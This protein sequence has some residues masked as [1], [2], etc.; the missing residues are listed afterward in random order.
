MLDRLLGRASLQRAHRRTRS[1]KR[2]VAKALRGRIR[3]PSRRRDGT[4]GR[5]GA[6]QPARGSDRPARGRTRAS[7]RGRDR[8]DRST[9]RPASRLPTRGGSRP[10]CVPPNG[11]RGC[12][13]RQRGRRGARIGP[14]GS[15][16]RARRSG[17]ARRRR[18][19]VSV[20]RRRRRIARRDARAADHPDVDAAW[21]DRFALEREWFLPT[22]RHAVA[23]VRTDLFALGVY[24]DDERVDYRGFES[25]VKGSHSKGGFSQARFERIRDGQIDDHLERCRD[26]L[27]AYEPGANAPIRRSISSA[28]GAPST[29]SSTN[30][31]S[32]RPRRPPSTRPAIRSR[33]SRT[34]SDC[35][36]RRTS[37]CCDTVCCNDVP[38]RPQ[39]GRGRTVNDLQ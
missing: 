23:L 34:P 31:G 10:A 8:T 2:A 30:R 19:A 21:R 28:S 32:S 36:G 14:C 26:A 20:L 39:G 38:V 17:R 5:R 22:G 9:P 7:G 3:T 11:G 13:D 29:R 35:S 4:T 25:D 27:S 24:E 12:V 15:G 37:G 16:R 6:D 33:R 18:R 1:G